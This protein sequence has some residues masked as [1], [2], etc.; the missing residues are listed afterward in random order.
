[1]PSCQADEGEAEKNA[2]EFIELNNTDC[3]SLIMNFGLDGLLTRKNF[4]ESCKVDWFCAV[5]I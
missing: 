1:M 2:V 5:A 3:K 4:K